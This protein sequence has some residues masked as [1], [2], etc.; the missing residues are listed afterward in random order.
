MAVSESAR[1]SR[2]MRRFVISTF[3]CEIIAAGL[4]L[5]LLHVGSS[6]LPE[7][8]LV[9]SDQ[10]LSGYIGI[11]I[12]AAVALGGSLVAIRLA[13]RAAD[14]SDKQMELTG[15]ANRI[16]ERQTPEAQLASEATAH[17]ERLKGMLITVPSL[18]RR[19]QMSVSSNN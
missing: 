11:V 15:M 3:V 18:I 2:I 7:P 1:D 19:A 9:L 16:A 13:E 14:S 12:G 6:Y 10:S 17:Y 4:S 5:A 8:D